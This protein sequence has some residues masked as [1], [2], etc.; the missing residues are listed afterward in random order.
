[1]TDEVFLDANVLLYA[2]SSASEDAAKRRVAAELILKRPLAL[3]IQR[4]QEFIANA[5]RQPR[6]GISKANI[7][8]TLQMASLVRVQAITRELVL[9]AI[10]V[11]Q[12]FGLSHWDSTITAAA[13]KL[14]CTTAHSEDLSDGQDYGGVR[15]VNPCK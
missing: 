6:L 3:S 9:S 11:R 8:A 2:C 13:A 14:G 15:V 1:M 7:N 12:R 5:V 10:A 4:L